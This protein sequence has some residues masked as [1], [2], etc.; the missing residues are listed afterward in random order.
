VDVLILVLVGALLVAL[1]GSAIS[2]L[3]SA[4]RLP[5]YAWKGAGRS[6]AGAILG[7]L[8]TGGVGGVY[9]WLSIHR[10]VT[11]ARDRIPPPPKHDPWSNGD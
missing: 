10:Q 11:A 1:W 2:A 4:A 5:G 9:Y 3:V 8:F 7:I 6:K